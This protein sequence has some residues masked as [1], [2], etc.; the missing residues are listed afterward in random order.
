VVALAVAVLGLVAVVGLR[1]A[2]LAVGGNMG[3]QN[4]INKINTKNIEQ[5]I[6]DFEKEVDF[7]FLPVIARKSSYVEHISWVISLILLVVSIGLIDWIFASYLYDSWLSKWPFYVA[8]PIVAFGLGVFLDKLDVVDRFFITK[9]ERIRQVQEKAEI[10]F[11]RK[12]LH[13]LKSKNALLL[14]ISVMERQIVLYHDPNMKFEQIQ[15]IESELLAVLQSSFKKSQY[16]EGLLAAI[17]HLKKSLQPYF[18][19]SVVSENAVANKLIWLN[20]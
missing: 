2:A 9:A 7:E 14:Y 15:Q 16:E 20:D 13:E 18:S 12:R 1:A 5:A 8:A 10:L 11:Y 19:K 6:A 3:L 17:S 4:A